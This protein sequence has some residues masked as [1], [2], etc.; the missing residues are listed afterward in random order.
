M[1]DTLLQDPTLVFAY[2]AAL[3]G[4]IFWLSG[5]PAFKWWFDRVPALVH[6]YFLP[7]LSSAFGVTPLQSPAYDWVSRFLLPLCL[8][9]LM[10]AVDLP[11]ILKVGRT[12]LLM[13]LAGTLGVIIGGPVAF[14]IFKGALP[15]DAWKAFAALSGSWI[16]G[17]ANFVAIAESVDAPDAVLGPAIVVD[18]V[19]GYSWMAVLLALS[20]WQLR[21]DTAIGARREAFE[22]AS[23]HLSE[24]QA[25][26][27]PTALRDI[28]IL[29]ALGFGGAAVSVAIGDRLP[30][31]GDPTIISSATWAVLV[32]VTAG[33]LLSFT[34]VRHLE[35][36]GASN[37]GYAALY[38]IIASI[39]AR[40]DLRAVLET[41]A[42][43]G[44][45]I[46]WIAIHVSILFLAARLLRAPLFF[47]AVGS[48]ANIG[49]AASAP[50]VAAAYHPAMAPV[51]LL[52]G[53]SGYILG[54]YGG[55][56]C[57]WLLG[58]AAG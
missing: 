10:V 16:G 55:L 49:G 39:G 38:L 25:H 44:A 18:T 4:A 24:L 9:L 58:L 57:A 36:V 7:T 28:L 26:K 22:E 54:I 3:V 27:R 41:P 15:P 47:V 53:V 45:G 43:L 51:G 21:F 13:M 12:A 19:V 30:A 14:L 1:P 17:S 48:M 50:V 5:H 31:V 52:L 6:C 2:L 40:A 34:P 42:F 8:L 46:V 33:I 56:A 11:A 29:V 37:V 23:R 20:A 32:A 35:E